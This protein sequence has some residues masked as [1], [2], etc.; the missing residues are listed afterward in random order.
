M[1]SQVMET[2]KKSFKFTE[3]SVV[4]LLSKLATFSKPE[5]PKEKNMA[6]SCR[7]GES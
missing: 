3:E 1:G 7:L 2:K 6:I 5:A 4:F